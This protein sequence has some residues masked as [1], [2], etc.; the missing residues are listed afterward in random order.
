M[1]TITWEDNR[2]SKR[3]EI[4]YMPNTSGYLNI[5]LKLLISSFLQI[6]FIFQ[7]KTSNKKI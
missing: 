3:R 7:D 6:H 1:K 5:K 4:I 2:L